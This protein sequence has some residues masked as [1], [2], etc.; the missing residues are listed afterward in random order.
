MRA[1]SVDC[2]IRRS[3]AARASASD[4]TVR[5]LNRTRDSTLRWRCLE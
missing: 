2:P 1:Q 4:Q 3:S 5:F